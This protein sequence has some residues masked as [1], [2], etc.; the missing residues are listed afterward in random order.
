MTDH[1]RH[2]VSMSPI[3]Q[4]LVLCALPIYPRFLGRLRLLTRL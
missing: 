4:S 2:R 1:T 3:F